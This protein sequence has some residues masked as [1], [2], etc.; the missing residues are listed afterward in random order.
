MNGSL[1]RDKIWNQQIWSEIDKAVQEEMGRTRVAQKVFPSVVVNNLL[2][3]ST[4]RIVPFGGGAPA[5]TPDQFQPFFEISKGFELTQAEV[6]DDENVHLATSFAR[7]AASVIANAEDTILFLGP[8]SINPILGPGVNVTNQPPPG[9]PPEFASI[10]PGFVAEAA[11]YTATDVPG[12]S[13]NAIGKILTGIE[14]GMT[15]LNQ[16][17]QPGPYALF[18]SPSRYAQAFEQPQAGL[19]ETPGDQIPHVVTGGFYMVNCLAEA[20][21]KKLPAP[22]PKK[23]P[24]PPP[25]VDIGIF[26]SLGGEPTKIILGT[27]AIAAFTYTDAKGNY[28]FRVFERIQMVV[29]DGRAFQ[30]LDF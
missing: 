28:H 22:P 17:D 3:V 6:D 19:L 29:R 12:S 1:G 23:P 13:P 24:A 27:D 10:P 14:K 11:K 21:L 2:P 30:I 18:L 26:V 25:E 15:E 4:K 8:G 20:K 5:P 7:S 9:M 16:R